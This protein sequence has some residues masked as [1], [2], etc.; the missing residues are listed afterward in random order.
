M[1]M[2]LG[3]NWA[4]DDPGLESAIIVAK[5]YCGFHVDIGGRRW[6]LGVKDGRM[7]EELRMD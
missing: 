6:F 5:V 4:V 7:N 3:I 2:E 1:V